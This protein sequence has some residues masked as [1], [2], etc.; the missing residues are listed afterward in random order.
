MI[1]NLIKFVLLSPVKVMHYSPSATLAN[2]AQILLV[3]TISIVILPI[4]TISGKNV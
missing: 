3:I 1:A 4:P 2:G